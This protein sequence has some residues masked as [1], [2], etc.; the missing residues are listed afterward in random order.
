M[1]ANLQCNMSLLHTR[2]ASGN[3]KVIVCNMHEATLIVMAGPGYEQFYCASSQC[4]T[5]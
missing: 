1:S 2:S 3:G 4:L 5:F